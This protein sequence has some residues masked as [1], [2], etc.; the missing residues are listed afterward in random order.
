MSLPDFNH[1]GDLPVAVYLATIDEILVRFGTGTLQR[2]AVTERFLKIFG[3]AK[4]TGKLLR[5]IIFGS[6][7]TNKPNPKDIDII[8]VMADDFL[9][10][11]YNSEIQ[12]IF[13]K[14]RKLF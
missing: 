11:D 2:Q 14:N 9:L 6:Y 5:F 7:I 4:S 3:I 12:A 10:D 1:Q 13:N 8:L